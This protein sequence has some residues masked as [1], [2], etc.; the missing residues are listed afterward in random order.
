MNGFKGYGGL[1]EG[2][3][4]EIVV[5]KRFLEISRSSRR[6]SRD[7][8][9]GSWGF[10]GFRGRVS[11]CTYKCDSEPP[12]KLSPSSS[13]SQCAALLGGSRKSGGCELGT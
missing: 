9:N 8:Q 2:F 5:Y 1:S 7:F 11:D 10:N 6:I 12:T 13:K 3:R 4:G